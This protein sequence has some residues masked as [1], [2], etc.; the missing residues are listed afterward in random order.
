MSKNNSDKE[1]QMFNGKLE[2]W[3]I[4]QKAIILLG[5]NYKIFEINEYAFFNL[6]IK[7][8]AIS[9]INNIVEGFECENNDECVYF[10]YASKKSC[11][12]LILKIMLATELSKISKDEAS[13]ILKLTNELI[14]MITNVT[15]LI[16]ICE[17]NTKKNRYLLV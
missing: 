1:M 7:D 12:G 17:V 8:A 3:I 15:D 4:W 9:I 6:Q 16:T 14:M 5:E 10:L 2:D 11:E 13:I